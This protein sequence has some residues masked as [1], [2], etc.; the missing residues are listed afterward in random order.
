MHDVLRVQELDRVDD[1]IRDAEKLGAIE[2]F[3]SNARGNRLPVDPLHDKNQRIAGW[4]D[5]LDVHQ[6]GVVERSAEADVADEGLTARGVLGQ[7]SR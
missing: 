4:G 7:L 5:F 2:R 3:V 1:L 6:R